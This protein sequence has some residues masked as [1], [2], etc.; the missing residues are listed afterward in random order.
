MDKDVTEKRKNECESQRD[1][2]NKEMHDTLSVMFDIPLPVANYE[3]LKCNINNQDYNYELAR[4]LSFQAF[5]YRMVRRNTGDPIQID[6]VID[7]TDIFKFYD[8]ENPILDAEKKNYWF[9]IRSELLKEY[10]VIER[11][12]RPLRF[13]MYFG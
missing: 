11:P 10:K 5:L 3:A 12:Q 9:T 4:I 1:T 2:D 6:D 7:Y 13:E 8:L